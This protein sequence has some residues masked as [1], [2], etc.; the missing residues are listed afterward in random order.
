MDTILDVKNKIL[1]ILKKEE[2]HTLINQEHSIKL[3]DITL[4]HE[5]KELIND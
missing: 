5:E 3:N 4:Y 2:E 1:N